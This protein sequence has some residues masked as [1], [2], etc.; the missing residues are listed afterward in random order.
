MKVID[1]IKNDKKSKSILVNFSL[2]SL[3]TYNL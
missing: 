1:D 3:R 2:L